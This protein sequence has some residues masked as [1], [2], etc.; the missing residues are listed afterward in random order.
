MLY[1]LWDLFQQ[2]QIA[3]ARDTAEFAKRD[4]AQNADRLHKE[5]LRLDAKIDRLAIISQALWELVRDKTGVTEKDIE[6]RIAEI[7]AR[8]GRKDGKITGRPTTCPKCDRPAHTRHRVCPY[9]GA[10]LDKG[11]I[12]EKS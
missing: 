8:D 7:D 9:C 5:V 10:A 12:V 2:G 11:H 1:D 4:A 3:S 6:A